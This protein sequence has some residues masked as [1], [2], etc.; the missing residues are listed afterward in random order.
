MMYDTFLMHHCYFDYIFDIV[1]F[2]I[3]SIGIVISLPISGIIAV[4][5]FKKGF[6]KCE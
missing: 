6:R 5:L 3:G 2:L 1:R 4:L